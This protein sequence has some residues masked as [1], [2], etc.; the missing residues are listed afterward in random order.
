MKPSDTWPPRYLLV[1]EGF[2]SKDLLDHAE[3]EGYG[4]EANRFAAARDQFLAKHGSLKGKMILKVVYEA[5][6][7]IS[8]VEEKAK[9][10]QLGP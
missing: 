7:E 3:P 1:K 6:R 5:D 8:D 9:D 10:G 4:W 2:R